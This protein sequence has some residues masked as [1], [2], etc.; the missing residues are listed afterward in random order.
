MEDKLHSLFSNAASSLTALYKEMQ[1]LNE[2]AYQQGRT[3]AIEE[4]IE[5]CESVQSQGF[6]YV[7][8]ATFLEMAERHS[9]VIKI[10]DFPESRKRIREI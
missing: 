7:P 3:E 9:S 4:L 8:I 5:W 10:Q 1:L 6:K 2:K